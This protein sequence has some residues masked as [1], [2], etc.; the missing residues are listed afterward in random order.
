MAA[1]EARGEA[2]MGD[3]PVRL[4]NL[5]D[6]LESDCEAVERAAVR[7][8]EIALRGGHATR[9]ELMR[10]VNDG[11]RFVMLLEFR[12]EE[13]MADYFE[14]PDRLAALQALPAAACQETRRFELAPVALRTVAG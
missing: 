9:A 8:A 3:E 10:D 12:S 2:A 11:C 14:D 1:D 7:L 13:R 6:A 5:I 4:L